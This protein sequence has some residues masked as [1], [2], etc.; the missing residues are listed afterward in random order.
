MR[1]F[2]FRG[3]ADGSAAAKRGRFSLRQGKSLKVIQLSHTKIGEIKGQNK[4]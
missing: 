2:S 4:M 1:S 3:G